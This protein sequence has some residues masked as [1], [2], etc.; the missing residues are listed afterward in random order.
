LHSSNPS[1]LIPIPV[2]KIH[3]SDA[4][5]SNK[6]LD[7]Y[8][9]GGVF[10]VTYKILILDLLTKKLSP[11]IIS[12]LIINNAHKANAKGAGNKTGEA[13]LA[14]IIRQGNQSVF[15]HA[16]TEKPS[17]LG[18]LNFSAMENMMKG[19]QVNQLILYPR[20]KKA[21]KDSLDRDNS[22]LNVTHA[23]IKFS[24]RIEEMHTLLIE[25]M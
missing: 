15:I 8:S 13:F 10:S 25:I 20:I 6:R 17:A 24:K 9:R 4:S 18:R 1:D 21:V 22:L 11:S 23:K 16:I 12:G 5:I 14:E 2:F 19:I 7:L 3:S